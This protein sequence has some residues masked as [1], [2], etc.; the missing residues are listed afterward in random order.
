MLKKPEAHA[1]AKSRLLTSI[2]EI[3]LVHKRTSEIDSSD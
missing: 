1:L 3:S 2:D